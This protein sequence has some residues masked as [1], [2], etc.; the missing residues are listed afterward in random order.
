MS[1]RWVLLS[2]GC[3]VTL[4]GNAK[5]PSWC[6]DC[7]VAVTSSVTPS[8]ELLIPHDRALWMAARLDELRAAAYAHD[9]QRVDAILSELDDVPA[10]L[11]RLTQTLLQ[12][13]EA[14]R[15]RP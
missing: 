5:A 6:P 11:A 9:D 12:D 3:Q 8:T 2:C 1:G 15:D 10:W 14:H 7:G 13:A 4:H